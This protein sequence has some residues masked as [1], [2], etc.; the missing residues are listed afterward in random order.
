[1]KKTFL[2]AL[3]LVLFT[4][5]AFATGD[6]YCK[7]VDGSDA[8]FGY[9]FGHVPGLAIVSAIISAEG[10]HWSMNDNE[11]SK[12]IV[13]AQGARDGAYTLIEFTDPGYE[14]IVASIRIVSVVEDGEHRAAGVLRIPNLGVYAMMCE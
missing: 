10:Q 1:M 5:T 8:E 12:P 11:G 9:S 2:L 14:A 13:V 6:S 3:I 4:N 7:A